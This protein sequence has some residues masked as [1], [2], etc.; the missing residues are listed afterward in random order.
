MEN[1][2]N[3]NTVQTAGSPPQGRRPVR[4]RLLWVVTGFCLLA[5][6]SF[7]AWLMSEAR[8][9]AIAR[10]QAVAAGRPLQNSIVPPNDEKYGQEQPV[11]FPKPNGVPSTASAPS[12]FYPNTFNGQQL[13]SYQNA[14]LYL[15]S[16]PTPF[17]GSNTY[18]AHES[19]LES[20]IQQIALQY[21][22]AELGKKESISQALTHFLTEL[23]DARHKAQ[24]SRVEAL[25]A[26][27]Q[28]TQELLDKRLQNKSKIIERR[29]KELTGQQ[30]ELSWNASVP[31]ANPSSSRVENSPIQ[32]PM[33]NLPYDAR[34]N[35]T[36]PTVGTSYPAPSYSVPIATPSDSYPSPT[37]VS[38]PPTSPVF[39]NA[40]SR[41]IRANDLN[42]DESLPSP[43]ANPT[44][45]V[46]PISPS[47][48]SNNPAN[49]N[50]E[51]QRSFMNIG[52]KIKGLTRQLEE[53]KTT[54]GLAK[55]KSEI[56]E[57]KVVWEF[58]KS[59][60]QS[61]L[62]SVESEY[63]LVTKQL[64]QARQ[65]VDIQQG[66]INTGTYAGTSADAQLN[67]SK[68]EV[69]KSEVERQLLQLRSRMSTIKKS[70]DWMENFFE[71]KSASLPSTGGEPEALPSAK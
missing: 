32:P 25:K 35:S 68:A 2:S 57:T 60:L 52:F 63:Q 10:A 33:Q 24:S 58:E 49:V 39:D 62:E 69:A 16:S 44:P 23:F 70:I 26:E 27:V 55:V 51:S 7:I 53:E 29:V 37:S 54:K 48:V 1:I 30:D 12:T 19:K 64:E 22:S 17:I 34:T 36:V 43:N 71:E 28:Q 11:Y 40:P 21:R 61:E 14:Q 6:V 4:K 3:P 46:V 13:S 50:L 5:V 8:A 9:L 56:E 45:T 42:V 15:S 18:D 66:R 31:N 65:Q 59:S 67:Y 47:P 20:R 41:T 38:I